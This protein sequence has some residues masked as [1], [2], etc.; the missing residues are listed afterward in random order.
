MRGK[1]TSFSFL[2]RKNCLRNQMELKINLHFDWQMGREYF[3]LKLCFGPILMFLLINASEKRVQ[4]DGLLLLNQGWKVNSD[5][6]MLGK[7]RNDPLLKIFA[8]T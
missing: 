6:G 4:N 5:F 3:F 7:R 8:D 2:F 1:S